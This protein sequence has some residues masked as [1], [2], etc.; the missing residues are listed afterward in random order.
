MPTNSPRFPKVAK[1]TRRLI[2]L[3]NEEERRK[4]AKMKTMPTREKTE[5]TLSVM[6][7]ARFCWGVNGGGDM[8]NTINPMYGL[9]DFASC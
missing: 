8:L 2:G 4:V 6:T 1:K 9:K 3:L 5:E 7:I